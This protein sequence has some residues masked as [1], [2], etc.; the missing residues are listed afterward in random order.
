MEVVCTQGCNQIFEDPVF[1]EEK[2]KDDIREVYFKC[3]HCGKKY[4]CFYTD[5]E[6]RKLQALQRKTKDLVE[7]DRLKDKVTN[8]MNKLK[9]E[10]KNR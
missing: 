1:K 8:R 6:I 3:P 9:E 10:M 4:T 7:F 2:V 5:R